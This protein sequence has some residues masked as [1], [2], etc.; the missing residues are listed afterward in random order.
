MTS[1]IVRKWLKQLGLLG[2]ARSVKHRFVGKP[3]WYNFKGD[4]RT[5]ISTLKCFSWLQE[6]GLLEGTDF[7]EFGIFRGFNLWMTQAYARAMGVTDMHFVGFDSFFGLPEVTGIDSGGPFK[8]GEFSAYREEVEHHLNKF[9]V[10]WNTTKLIEGYFDK[11][12]NSRTIREHNLRKCSLCVVDCDLYSSTVP[13]LEF[14][15][16]LLTSPAIIFFD[17]W[18]DF[19]DGPLQ[20]E[21]KA[22]AEFMA[23][24]T[25]SLEAEPFVDLL[26]LGGKGKAFIIRKIRS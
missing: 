16:S 25:A 23:A 24:N 14:V 10:N 2:A 12:L 17:D 15:R 4:P 1:L 6:Q 21:P 19:A 22:F 13:V 26:S 3:Q 11:T 8:E 20:G 18:N 9:G 5:V 7:F